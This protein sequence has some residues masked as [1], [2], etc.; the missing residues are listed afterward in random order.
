MV[1]NRCTKGFDHHCALANNCVGSSNYRHFILS[2]IF[3][4]LSLGFFIALFVIDV[5]IYVQS[6]DQFKSRL[7]FSANEL[8]GI[9]LISITGGIAF[10][11]AILN[12]YIIGFHCFLKIKKIN[13]YQYTFNHIS[14]TVVPSRIGSFGP[15]QLEIVELDSMIPQNDL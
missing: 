1:C 12:G 9:L 15:G 2:I 8:Y 5:L 11:S 4:E 6:S 3:A 14:K 10:I 7:M 13:T